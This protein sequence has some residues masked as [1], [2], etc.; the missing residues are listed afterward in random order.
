M[1]YKD[2]DDKREAG[3]RINKLRESG[4][5]VIDD[6]KK[7]YTTRMGEYHADKFEEFLRPRTD[8]NLPTIVTTNMME[9]ELESEFPRIFSLLMAKNAVYVL[10]GHDARASGEVLAE[11]LNLAF[12]G[13]IRPII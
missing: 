5:V 2:I 7:P 13:E 1:G 10:G 6:L 4:L 11:N 8:K 12:A 3:W 9:S